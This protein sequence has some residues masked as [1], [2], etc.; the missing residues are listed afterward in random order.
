MHAKKLVKWGVAL[1]STLVLGGV[2]GPVGGQLLN[3][4]SIV[5]AQ[6]QESVT[7]V[8]TF[9]DVS[10]L[11]E[12]ADR[13]YI[14]IKTGESIVYNYPVFDGYTLHEDYDSV[15]I[16]DYDSVARRNGETIATGF[17]KVEKPAETPTEQPVEQPVEI[18]VEQ[19]TEVPV[20]TP[21]EQPTD[22]PTD[23]PISVAI[24]A[25]SEADGPLSHY[26]VTLNPG[27]TKTVEAPKVD[28]YKLDQYAGPTYELTYDYALGLMN[29]GGS[30]WVQ[31]WMIKDIAPETPVDQPVEQPVEKPVETPTEQPVET[32]AGQPTEILATTP[33][34]QP[35]EQPAEKPVEQPVETP[36]GQPTETPVEKPVETPTEKPVEQLVE[37]PTD[38]PTG[39]PTATS[40][41]AGNTTSKAQTVATTD[42]KKVDNSTPSTNTVKPEEG[43]QATA[44]TLP[45]TGD[46]SSILLGLGGFLSGL[47]GLGLA[48]TSRKRD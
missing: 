24:I 2:V 29:S 18:P 7:A 15:L 39:K 38:Q 48:A 45:K 37:T 42:K 9:Y 1:T 27:E 30:A 41:L 47:S 11:S 22:K 36:A 43:S 44:K 40:L 13:V 16:L 32:P 46:S 6:N 31:F 23:Q 35:V 5:Y 12:I 28:G 25:I 3:A 33:I 26:Y 20:E 17:R 19:P 14:D 10:D 8:L 34:E 4:S 21:T